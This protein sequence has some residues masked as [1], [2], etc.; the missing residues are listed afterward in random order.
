MRWEELTYEELLEVAKSGAIAIIPLGSLEVHDPHLPLGTDSLA[1]YKVAIE[2]AKR[3]AAVVLPLLYYAC[4]IEN[5]HFPGT[6]SISAHLLLKLLEEICDEIAR[7]G[8]HKILIINGHGGNRRILR[9]F[10]REFLWKHKGYQ[11]Y[12]LYDPWAPIQDIIGK[13]CKTSEIGHACEVETS[14]MLYLFPKLVK[15]NRVRSKAQTGK[16]PSIP[17]VETPVDWTVYCVMG[18]V[19]DPRRA[20]PEK[21]KLLY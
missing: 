12:I 21:G 14:Y 11:I 7:N 9:L 18:Y 17:F 19:G 10:A 13:V 15:M 16:T 4:V 3:E 5:R 2:A 20:N 6:I 8:F 1:I